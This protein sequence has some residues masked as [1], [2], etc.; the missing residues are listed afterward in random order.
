MF[1]MEH[2]YGKEKNPNFCNLKQP[3]F[4]KFNW[5]NASDIHRYRI[6][7]GASQKLHK[8]ALYIKA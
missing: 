5:S 6:I 8:W 3:A 1:L 4:K 7:H 2:L